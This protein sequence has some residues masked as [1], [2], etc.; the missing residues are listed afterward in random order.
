VFSLYYDGGE[1]RPEYVVFALIWCQPVWDGVDDPDSSPA[2]PAINDKAYVFTGGDAH[3]N[4]HVTTVYHD[5]GGSE[6]YGGKGYGLWEYVAAPKW[7]GKDNPT[8]AQGG[9]R[10]FD[11]HAPKGAKVFAVHGGKVKNSAGAGAGGNV[12]TLKWKSAGNEHAEIQ[13]LHNSAFM[14]ANNTAVRAGQVVAHA[15]RTGNLTDPSAQPGHVHVSVGPNNA[16]YNS[17]DGDNRICLP[18]NQK[19]PLVFPCH[20][21]VTLAASNPAGCDFNKAFAKECWAVAELACPYMPA[22]VALADMTAEGETGSKARRRL[23]AQLRY[24]HEHDS[25]SYL[26]PGALDADIGP[27]PPQPGAAGAPAYAPGATRLAIHKYKHARGLLPN[28]PT[29]EQK[30]GID[31][32][33]LDDLDVAAPLTTKR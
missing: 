10:G 23:Q 14:V 5:L 25:A 3:L 19:T 12:V 32:A 26:S 17:P 7:R 28:G 13:Y 21:E 11:L 20:C 24:M 1:D 33:L 22:T 6:R 16:L 31:Q 29:L 30:Y 9:H 4:M 27:A 18:A 2:T 15:G 8:D